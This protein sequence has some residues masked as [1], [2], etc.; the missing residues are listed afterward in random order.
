MRENTTRT[1]ED[2]AVEFI[3][4]LEYERKLALKHERKATNAADRRYWRGKAAGLRHGISIA[5]SITDTY[6]LERR[7]EL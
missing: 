3:K 4:S 1:A 2:W 5:R 6:K 7:G